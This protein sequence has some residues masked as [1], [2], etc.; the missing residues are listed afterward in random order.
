M[1][2]LVGLWLVLGVVLGQAHAQAR[3]TLAVLPL[4]KAS[5][6]E[7]YD[8]LGKALAG[9]LVTDLSKIPD[10]ELVERDRLQELLDEMNLAET[11]FLDEKTAQKLGHGLGAKFVLTGSYSVVADTFLLDARVIEVE[12]GTIRN[13][14]D[15]SGS[16]TDFVTVEKDLVEALVGALDVEVSSGVRRQMLLGAPTE[17][18][19][20]FS[21]YGEG[22]QRQ[23]EGDLEAARQAFEKALT[24]DPE[25]DAAQA[26]LSQVRAMLA[27]FK[28]ERTEKFH[29]VYGEMNK[30]A[31]DAF[32]ELP[33]DAELDMDT[34]VG[35]SL[36]LAALENEERDCQRY[37]EMWAFLDASDWA[38]SE[39][40]KRDVPDPEGRKAQQFSGELKWEAVDQ[41]FVPYSRDAGGPDIAAKSL[42]SRYNQIFDSTFEFITPIGLSQVVRGDEHSGLLASMEG[43]FAP[44]DRL[45]E[46]DRLAKAL[47]EAGFSEEMVRGDVAVADF[48]DLYWGYTHARW[49]GA[50]PELTKRSE[51][52]LRRTKL[53]DPVNAAEDDK[54]R[55]RESVRHIEYIVRDAGNIEKWKRQRGGMSVEETQVYLRGLASLDPEVVTSEPVMCGWMVDHTSSMAAMALDGFADIEDDDWMLIGVRSGTGGNSQP[56]LRRAGCLVG[57]PAEFETFDQVLAFGKEAHSTYERRGETSC[58]S[59]VRGL[60]QIVSSLEAI[61]AGAP[62]MEG[63]DS[64]Q[65][66]NILNMFSMADAEGCFD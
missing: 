13:A 39:P 36:R 2:A 45:G 43:C 55:E 1:N 10:L 41:S 60:G 18:F 38:V 21:A 42:N 24:H 5:A 23:D 53:D 17:D 16:V 37:R 49:L 62:M 30:R 20:A 32:G 54:D 28:A 44:E 15:A 7:Q 34:V 58:D 56:I 9:M 31:L 50:S 51:R 8:G 48:L 29:A 57:E 4:D 27:E 61:P 65:A 47:D 64:M 33:A 40:E 14:A 46:I 6:S 35:F 66:W 3:P 26:S 52:V 59:Y 12:S 25:F 19:G 63:Y 11:G 22:I